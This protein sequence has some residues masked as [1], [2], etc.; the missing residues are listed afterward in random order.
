[1]FDEIEETV[2]E[3][4]DR[5]TNTENV[6]EVVEIEEDDNV[7]VASSN[8]KVK[9]TKLKNVAV[10]ADSLETEICGVLMDDIPCSQKLFEC[11]L[12]SLTERRRLPGR[13]R[14]FEKLAKIAAELAGIPLKGSQRH[15]L[16]FFYIR[17]L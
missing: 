3:T 4:R 16:I 8:K 9:K 6:T 14:R 1:M 2:K 7:S 11:N 5:E 12:H 10:T 15:F 17:I 13:G